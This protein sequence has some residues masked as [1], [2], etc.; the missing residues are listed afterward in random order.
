MK[1]FFY[2]YT[3]KLKAFIKHYKFFA[4]ILKLHTL[5]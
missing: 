4:S 2:V 1:G 3:L 5:Y